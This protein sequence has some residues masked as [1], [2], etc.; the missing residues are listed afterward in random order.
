MK[1]PRVEQQREELEPDGEQ[2]SDYVTNDVEVLD[3]SKTNDES[4]REKEEVVAG[5]EEENESYED[6]GDDAEEETEKEE[7]EEDQ[8]VEEL[9]PCFLCKSVI[10][11]VSK[12]GLQMLFLKIYLSNH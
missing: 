10:K 11:I 9:L 8:E 12:D 3:K 1:Y 2:Q 5:G 6:K 4:G 7:E